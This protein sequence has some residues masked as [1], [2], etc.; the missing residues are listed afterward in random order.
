VQPELSTAPVSGAAAGR[1]LGVTWLDG[2]DAVATAVAAD[3]VDVRTAGGSSAKQ[4]RRESDPSDVVHLPATRLAQLAAVRRAFPSAALVLDLRDRDAE[5]GWLDGRRA[6]EADAI[7]VATAD[8]LRRLPVGLRARAA[9][10]PP[11]V[12]LDVYQPL[13]R[14]RERRDAELKRFRRLHRLAGPIVLYAGPY[15]VAGGLHIAIEL[16]KQLREHRPELRLAAIPEGRV[17]GRYLR[18]CDGEA[19]GL[20]HHGI[21]EWSPSESDRTLWYALAAVVC[22]PSPS[23]GSVRPA[24]LAA[25]AARPVVGSRVE[26]LVE[27]VDEGVTGRLVPSGD[28]EALAAAVGA[29][30]EDAEGAERLGEQARA[31]AESEWS[32]AAA[33]NRLRA[34]WREASERARR[35]GSEEDEAG[36]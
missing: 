2:D 7:V 26:P 23:S 29:L 35:R 21:I 19:L 20:G 11:P 36:G 22:L 4:W 9:V 30:V 34:I 17:D 6:R 13:H 18:T 24:Q 10:A 32:P 15:D 25:A 12:A 16:A 28:V 27:L 33:A 1:R 14:L 8:E 5:L 31:R 3:G